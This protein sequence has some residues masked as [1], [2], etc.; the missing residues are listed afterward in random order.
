MEPSW[1][2]DDEADQQLI[3]HCSRCFMRA[4]PLSQ[5]SSDYP[6][7]GLDS[8]VLPLLHESTAL[9]S[10]STVLS[11][12]PQIDDDLQLIQQALPESSVIDTNQLQLVTFASAS[13]LRGAPTKDAAC[14]PLRLYCAADQSMPA[15]DSKQPSVGSPSGPSAQ[16]DPEQKG[17]LADSTSPSLASTDIFSRGSTPVLTNS[18]LESNILPNFLLAAPDQSSCREYCS[19]AGVYSTRE[20]MY[21]AAT[22][23][24]APALMGKRFLPGQAAANSTGKGKVQKVSRDPQSVAARRRR[25]RIREKLQEL[26]QLLPGGGACM[27]T[28]AV[29]EEAVHYIA[30]LKKEVEA[31]GAGNSRLF[32]LMNLHMQQPP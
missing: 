27:D 6:L 16:Q 20:M 8:L 7:S 29:L 13:G 32:L 2:V 9:C 19:A 28:A 15:G 11:P 17:S 30:F 22:M 21:L 10:D 24:S 25:S 31:L 5:Y 26:Q 14:P 1:D 18:E 23:Q 4:E 3:S 12:T